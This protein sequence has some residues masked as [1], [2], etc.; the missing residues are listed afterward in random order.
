[1]EDPADILEKDQIFFAGLEFERL[2]FLAAGEPK[3]E[4]SDFDGE[5]RLD[6]L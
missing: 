4:L 6:E 1:M 3:E 5:I 2:V